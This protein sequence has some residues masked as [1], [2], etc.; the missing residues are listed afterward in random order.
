MRLQAIQQRLDL[1]GRSVLDLGCATGGMLLH[2]KDPAKAIGWDLDGAAISA[3]GCIVKELSRAAPEFSR[4]FSFK[5]VDLDAQSQ[6]LLTDTIR[7]NSIDTIFLLSIGSWVKKWRD[8]YAI[9]ANS[10]AVIVLETNND[11]EGAV[12]LDFLKARGVILDEIVSDSL[13]DITGNTGR[14]TYVSQALKPR[15]G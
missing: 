1:S 3:A 14:R 11:T 13:D 5:Q 2:L 12:Q 8:Y 4:R 10:G 15:L 7:N 6:N 9:A